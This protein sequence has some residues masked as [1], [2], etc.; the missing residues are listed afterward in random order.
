MTGLF[1]LFF[2]VVAEKGSGEL[3][4]AVLCRESPDL[5]IVNW[6]LIGVDRLQRCKNDGKLCMAASS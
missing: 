5:A 4:L 2:F 1:F 6:P 3:L